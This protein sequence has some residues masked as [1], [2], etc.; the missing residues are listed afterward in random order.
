MRVRNFLRS[1]GTPESFRRKVRQNARRARRFLTRIGSAAYENS[2]TAGRIDRI[3]CRIERAVDRD[4]GPATAPPAAAGVAVGD[5]PARDGARAGVACP[6]GAGNE[7]KQLAFTLGETVARVRR[8]DTVKPR[9]QVS[10]S[11]HIDG[12]SV[13]RENRRI[14]CRAKFVVSFVGSQKLRGDAAAGAGRQRYVRVHPPQCRLDVFVRERRSNRLLGDGARGHD[15][16][17]EERRRHLQRIG[18]IVEAVAD[19]VGGKQGGRVHIDVE[20]VTHGVGVFGAIQAVNPDAAGVEIRGAGFVQRVLKIGGKR[21]DRGRGRLGHAG[22]RHHA[23][24]QFANGPLPSLRVLF[25]VVEIYQIEGKFRGAELLIV[26]GD[27][28]AVDERPV[29]IDRSR[30]WSRSGF[31]RLRRRRGEGA[32]RKRGEQ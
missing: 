1:N 8:D 16:L 23:S 13:H 26:A 19:I 12:R 14:A 17:V 31:N 15:V 2:R 24:A 22:R 11:V 28:V 4:V 6:R 21:I 27:A 18:D 9:R 32:C 30:R 3:A 7:A 25:R 29:R 5:N 10:A 20:H